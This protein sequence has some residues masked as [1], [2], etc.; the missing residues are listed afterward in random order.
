MPVHRDNLEEVVDAAWVDATE[1]PASGDNPGSVH[2]KRSAQ[3]VD[4]LAKQFKDNYDLERRHRVFWK[5]YEGNKEHFGVNELLFDITVCSIST[6]PSLQRNPKGLEFIT[7]CHWQVESEFAD[8]NTRDVIVDMSKL[9]LGSAE[10]KLIVA[11]RRDNEQRQRD[12]LAQ[13]ADIAACCRTN[14]FF[15]FVSHPRTWLDA[16]TPNPP[17]LYEWTAGDWRLIGARSD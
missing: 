9:V 13:C 1:N 6:T 12:V 7:A 14:V 17:L 16:P 10:N 2:R 15:L 3:W 4:A 8:K 5:G 11:A